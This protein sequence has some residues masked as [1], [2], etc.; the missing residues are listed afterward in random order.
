MH[1]EGNRNE[2]HRQQRQRA[3]RRSKNAPD[4]NTPRTARYLV[5][6]GEAERPERDRQQPH[7]GRQERADE[8]RRI[9]H[10][11]DR[12]HGRADGAADE[13]R[14]LKL[15]ELRNAVLADAF[16]LHVHFKRPCASGERSLE[17]A[18]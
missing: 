11:P 17:G 16:Q 3:R 12:A 7:V 2:Q 6:H 5:H 13:Q 8:L 15:F 10:E 9:H 1:A 4:D 14:R 18:F